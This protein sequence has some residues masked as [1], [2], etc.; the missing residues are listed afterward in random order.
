[1]KI[2][3]YWGLYWGPLILGNYHIVLSPEDFTLPTLATRTSN[4]ANM[5]YDPNETRDLRAQNPKP[6]IPLHPLPCWGLVRNM[7]IYYMRIVLGVSREYGNTHYKKGF[8]IRI[9]FPPSLLCTRKLKRKG[10]RL[11]RISALKR[12]STPRDEARLEASDS[13]MP[14]KLG[15]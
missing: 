13:G 9:I 6:Q 11:I 4:V 2:I 7:G 14:R 8:R 15:F 5:F 10:K 3:V 1:M 12:T